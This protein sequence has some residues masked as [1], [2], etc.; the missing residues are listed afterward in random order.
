MR[1]FPTHHPLPDL[2][3]EEKAAA[4]PCAYFQAGWM[5]NKTRWNVL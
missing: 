4:L 1:P 2:F 5:I 3:P